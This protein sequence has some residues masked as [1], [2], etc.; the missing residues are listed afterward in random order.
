MYVLG[1][2]VGGQKCL[3]ITWCAITILL[4]AGAFLTVA[5]TNNKSEALKGVADALSIEKA[6]YARVLDSFVRVPK[7]VLQMYMTNFDS[8]IDMYEKQLAYLMPKNPGTEVLAVISEY[9]DSI[10]GIVKRNLD[11][12]GHFDSI[13]ELPRIYEVYKLF[14]SRVYG[15]LCKMT[16]ALISS[17]QRMAMLRSNQ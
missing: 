4:I 1:A 10:K 12:V 15:D 6:D 13:E 3:N 11:M 5:I 17:L 7:R 14:A 9:T 8:T 2:G 16:D